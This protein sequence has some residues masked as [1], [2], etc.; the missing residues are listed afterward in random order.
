[1][2]GKEA[3]FSR[4]HAQK[5]NGQGWNPYTPSYTPY[6]PSCSLPP[7]LSPPS[8]HPSSLLP[9]LCLEGSKKRLINSLEQILE[10]SG[11]FT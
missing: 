10:G 6:T 1:M 11:A 8:S 4:I 7:S 2:G 5:L 3:A 9:S